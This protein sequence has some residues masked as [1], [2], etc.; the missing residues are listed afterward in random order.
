MFKKYTIAVPGKSCS[1]LYSVCIIYTDI[2]LS[3][4]NPKGSRPDE[5][6]ELSSVSCRAVKYVA[7]SKII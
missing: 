7:C 2:C 6:R 1:Y 5:A 4:C 3:L